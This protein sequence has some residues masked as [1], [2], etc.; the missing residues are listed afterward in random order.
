MAKLLKSAGIVAALLLAMTAHAQSSGSSPAD[1]VQKLLAQAL[2][3]ANQAQDSE[4]KV[5]VLE[6]ILGLEVYVGNTATARHNLGAL[7]KNDDNTRL[8]VCEVVVALARKGD[9]R[10][11]FAIL[12]TEGADVVGDLCYSNMADAQG[13]NGDVDGAVESASHESEPLNRSMDLGSAARAAAA[14]GKSDAADRL[15]KLALDAART[16]EDTGT[17]IESLR[18]LAFF[19]AE[20]NRQTE[21]VAFLPEMQAAASG[22]KDAHERDIRLSEIAE[23]Q[24]GAGLFV[25]ADKTIKTIKDANY[26]DL[27]RDMLAGALI[28]KGDLA[29]ALRNIQ[30]IKDLDQR[31][32]DSVGLARARASR[33]DAA[34]ALAMA[35]AAPDEF[36]N[37]SADSI[38]AVI[39]SEQAKQ[40]KIEDAKGTAR[41]ITS[42]RVRARTLILLGANV[43]LPDKDHLAT[44]V[45]NEARAAA[46]NIEELYFRAAA[47]SHLAG[48]LSSR[49]EI[50]AA[51]DAADAIPTNAEESMQG[52]LLKHK[53]H[54]LE[55]ISYWQ[56]KLGDC[57]NSL[58]WVVK[59]NSPILRSFAIA[60]AIEAILGFKPPSAT[61]GEEG[62][63]WGISWQSANF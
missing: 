31:S 10:G 61:Y 9:V 53:G 25:D 40:G 22:I 23:V 34:G 14:A 38:Y 59:E 54:S 51:R 48:V 30:M 7:S 6:T 45:F 32:N 26:Q 27:A 52:D 43:P 58:N 21:I 15:F 63:D 35:G 29:G 37:V 60:G 33:G 2:D 17:K 49:G 1:D 8:V 18:M 5:K 57:K 36:G 62:Y 20:A 55:N 42:S 56:C 41:L 50:S 3:A 4:A 28:N 11:A 47:L 19:L 46:L 39:A 24:A 44:A 12:S 13:Q 16:V